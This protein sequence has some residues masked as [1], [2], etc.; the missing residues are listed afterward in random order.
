MLIRILNTDTYCTVHYGFMP[1]T[2]IAII[3]CCFT[4]CV[5]RKA[6]RDPKCTQIIPT[7]CPGSLI[8][9]F[10]SAGGWTLER[11]ITIC[12]WRRA[13]GCETWPGVSLSLR[14]VAS[15]Q[16][17]TIAA[18]A[19]AVLDLVN[20]DPDTDIMLKTGSTSRLFWSGSKPDTFL[21][22]IWKN[23][24]LK[25]ILHQTLKTPYISS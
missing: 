20:P 7:T 9:V 19:A 8:Y 22:K 2:M 5:K 11:S 23:L 24:Q 13:R 21:I 6:S 1:M 12:P 17:T 4:V 18:L 3:S 10:N 16:G 25:E 14:T 15:R